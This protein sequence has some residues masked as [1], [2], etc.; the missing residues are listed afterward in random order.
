MADAT[1]RGSG[2][3]RIA[4]AIAV[5]AALGILLAL[6]T[7]QV[8][9]LFWKE[10]LL[11]DIQQRTQAA[12]VS[13]SEIERIAATGGD[14]DYRRM[15]VTGRFDN[16]RERHFLATFNGDSGFYI[17]APLVMADGRII[18]VN[19][20]FVPY[21]N[22]EPEMR[23]LGQLTDVVTLNGLSRARLTGKPSFIVPDNDLKKNVFYWKDLDAMISSTGLDPAKVEPFFMD[24][25]RM[26]IPG[27]MPIGG[28]TIID[29]PNNHLQYAITWYGLAVA[30]AGIAGVNWWRGRR[31]P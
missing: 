20:G 7:W 26:E 22:K 15:T 23:V 30:L 31:V 18:M 5:L 14:V 12:P 10:A 8:E 11:A 3:R 21:E 27:G 29:L 28:V 16:S 24:A 4:T 9:R 13:V 25:D 6:G 2:G 19:R 1:A 17:Y